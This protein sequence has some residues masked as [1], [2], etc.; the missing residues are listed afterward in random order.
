MVELVKV[1]VEILNSCGF[2]VC[3]VVKFVCEIGWFDVV[4]LV[5]KDGV[6]VDGGLIM[7]LFMFVV[8]KG[9]IICIFVDG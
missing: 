3:V 7:G 9:L 8:V 2:Y 6:E 1:Y 5:F 4:I